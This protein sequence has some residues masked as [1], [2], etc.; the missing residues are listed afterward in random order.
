MEFNSLVSQLVSTYD[1]EAIVIG[2]TGGVEPHGGIN[3]WHSSERLHLWYP[4]QEA[5]ATRWEAAINELFVRGSREMDEAQRYA[6]YH[7]FQQVASDNLP[8]I[9][10]AL[11]E[12]ITAFR[13]SYGNMT[14]TL[15]GL[16]DVRYL[17]VR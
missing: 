14:P 1:W 7:E 5:P 3:L 17:Y 11:A 6:I 16:Y 2:F 8:V 10:T 12:R 15:Y 9:Y 13:N 4:L